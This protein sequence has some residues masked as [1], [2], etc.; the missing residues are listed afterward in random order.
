MAD[1]C[2][3]CGESFAPL[4][5]FSKHQKPHRCM[6]CGKTIGSGCYR[7]GSGRSGRSGA[8]CDPCWGQDGSDYI[9]E[10]ESVSEAIKGFF[11]V[12][13]RQI[14]IVKEDL[15]GEV[16]RLREQTKE[17]VK[18]ITAEIKG[19][20]HTIQGDVKKDVLEIKEDVKRDLE[21]KM[22]RVDGLVRAWLDHAQG[23]VDRSIQK[24]FGY[25]WITMTS[26][27]FL[28]F[29]GLIYFTMIK[30]QP[31]AEVNPLSVFRLSLF[32]LVGAPTL[33]WFFSA[34]RRALRNRTLKEYLKEKRDGRPLA[35]KDY[36]FGFLY[37]R[38][39]V[40]NIWGP[41]FFLGMFFATVIYLLIHLIESP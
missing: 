34:A 7:V 37:F 20:I 29:V 28:T 8:I 22:D 15:K 2:A 13:R 27:L 6:V 3:V 40:Q 38:D 18:E 9:P 31:E 25:L 33:F 41:V 12:A 19:E 35:L 32:V 5:P 39:P 16:Q 14:E 26:T 4:N 24:G 17:D 21:A 11:P 30:E 36:L 1:R 23:Q 10:F